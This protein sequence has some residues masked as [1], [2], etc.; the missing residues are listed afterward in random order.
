MLNPFSFYILGQPYGDDIMHVS[1]C[2]RCFC[3]TFAVGGSV[4]DFKKENY[5]KT[6]AYLYNLYVSIFT[7]TI[8]FGPRMAPWI[9]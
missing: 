5:S 7:S 2:R 6:L 1:T 4:S 3:F 8:S 9:M